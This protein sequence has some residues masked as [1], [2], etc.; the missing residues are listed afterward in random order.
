M[1]THGTTIEEHQTM[2]A[3][4][5]INQKMPEVE[6]RDLFAMSSMNA[7]IRVRHTDYE[8]T[9]DDFAKLSYQYADSMLKARSKK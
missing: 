4:Q 6:L 5:C 2:A 1:E 8:M 9:E 3:I 7:L